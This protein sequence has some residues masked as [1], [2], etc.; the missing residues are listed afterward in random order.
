MHFVHFPQMMLDLDTTA[1]SIQL[2]LT[3][4]MLGMAVGQLV[5]GPLS[6]QFGRRKPLLIGALLCLA[7]SA[8]CAVTPNI[9]TLIGFRFF[10]GFAG[11]AG[12]VLAR[13]IVSDSAR[14]MYAAKQFG[15]LMAVGGIAPVLSPLAGGGVIAF[16]GWRGVFWALAVLN[17]LMVIGSIIIVKES[18]PQ[19]HRSKGGVKELLASTGRVLSNRRYLGFT[20]AFAFAM[21]AMFGYISASP[22]VY[23]NILGLNPTAFSLLFALNALG[24]TI[25]SIVGVKLVGILSPLRMT[26][27]GVSGLV[28]FSAGLLA[29]VTAGNT[30]LFPTL[31]LIFLAISS[32]GLIFGNAAALATD[33][34]RKYAGTGSAVMGALQF[35]LAAIASPLVGLAGEGSAGPM[36]IVMLV[37][38]IIALVSLLAFTRGGA[39]L[40]APAEQ[41]EQRLEPASR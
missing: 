26:Y 28:V 15:I 12:V 27:I 10:Q 39:A 40:P 23:Q 18:L 1:A 30:P 19:E 31:A 37:A 4:F 22:F 41:A 29:V 14:G 20:F 34:V 33:Q 7:A 25:T 8:P 36:A 5:I 3:A 11:A 13:A 32:L 38:G 35:M 2:T 6:D 17:L 9:E 24:I 16:A 21:A